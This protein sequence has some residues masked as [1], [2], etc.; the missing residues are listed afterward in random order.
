MNP[1]PRTGRAQA[2]ERLILDRLALGPCSRT[3]LVVGLRISPSG[4][5]GALRRLEARGLVTSRMA[6][7]ALGFP[8][9]L[10]RVH[11]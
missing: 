2:I 11:A 10:W 6:E 1:Y 4:V 3:T 9:R 5:H 8:M 7:P